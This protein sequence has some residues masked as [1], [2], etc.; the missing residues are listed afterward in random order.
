MVIDQTGGG[1]TNLTMDRQT[2]GGT[3]YGRLVGLSS[4]NILYDTLGTLDV[5]LGAAADT[6]KVRSTQAGLLTRVSTGGGTDSVYVGSTDL[7]STSTVNDLSGGLVIDGQG[8]SDTIRVNDSG[9]SANNGGMLTFNTITGLGT[10]GITYQNI[11]TL[12]I[13]LG[14][15]NDAFTIA[16]THANLTN[17]RSQGGADSIL[18][19]STSGY[20]TIDAGAGADTI[21]VGDASHPLSGMTGQID[22]QGGADAAADT[23]NIDNTAAV[24]GQ[25]GILTASGLT[26][27]GMTIGLNYSGIENFNL[28]LGQG[29]DN[30][31]IA[32][33]QHSHQYHRRLLGQ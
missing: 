9:D 26:G 5:N 7:D 33:N 12:N 24:A 2:I 19:Q 10:A 6:V 30:L 21:T 1:A 27:F 17:L 31:Y 4:A 3:T 8:G 11:E 20:T 16:S 23:L 22:I 18:V 13:D 25:S 28:T 29:D 32:C 14:S 15:G